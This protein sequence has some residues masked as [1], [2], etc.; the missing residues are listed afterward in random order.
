MMQLG[1]SQLK[2]NALLFP[3]RERWERGRERERE[4]GCRNQVNMTEMEV[5][6]AL[7]LVKSRWQAELRSAGGWP[8]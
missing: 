3:A 2:K 1:G 6:P 4:M 8:C 7:S 5:L